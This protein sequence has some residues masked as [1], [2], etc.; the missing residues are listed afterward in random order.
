MYS[1]CTANWWIKTE[2]RPE[3]GPND[4]EFTGMSRITVWKQASLHVE[5]GLMRLAHKTRGPIYSGLD[6]SG[7]SPQTI[8]AATS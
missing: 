7:A 4:Y 8:I 2:I 6:L 1:P 3:K 5:M